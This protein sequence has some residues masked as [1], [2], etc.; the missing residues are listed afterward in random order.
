MEISINK[1]IAKYKKC[2]NNMNRVLT[3][4]PPGSDALTKEFNAFDPNTNALENNLTDIEIEASHSKYNNQHYTA[5]KVLRRLQPKQPKYTKPAGKVSEPYTHWRS[6]QHT[7]ESNDKQS[8]N[9]S[10]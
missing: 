3:N 10:N 9:H 8:S 7:A 1:L 4:E 2:I 5:L 6:L